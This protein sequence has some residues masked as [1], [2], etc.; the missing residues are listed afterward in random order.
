MP[1][2]SKDPSKFIDL[3]ELQ[4]PALLDLVFAGEPEREREVLKLHQVDE[5]RRILR[6]AV[7]HVEE[8]LAAPRLAM[9]CD[10]Q[11]MLR[12]LALVAPRGREHRF[13]ERGAEDVARREHDLVRDAGAA[14]LL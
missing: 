13:I 3:M 2:T 11:R 7:E 9:Q 1:R 4:Y 14:R 5:L 10:E 12:P 8:L 6:R